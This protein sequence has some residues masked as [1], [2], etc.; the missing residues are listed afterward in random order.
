[1]RQHSGRQMYTHTTKEE[2]TRS[3]KKHKSYHIPQTIKPK[4]RKK[5]SQERN[6]SQILKHGCEEI[7]LSQPNLQKRISQIP[8]T[9]KNN[10]TSKENLETM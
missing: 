3:I 1:M 8:N 5:N 6:P 10:G 9:R 4:K 2:Q 7:P